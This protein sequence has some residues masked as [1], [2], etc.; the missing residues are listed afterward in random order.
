MTSFPIS[1]L[2]ICLARPVLQGSVLLWGPHSWTRWERGQ[3]GV[4][5][6]GS[7]P[8]TSPQQM[9]LETT[10]FCW[11]G[12]SSGGPPHLVR[13]EG[14][15]GGGDGEVPVVS[16]SLDHTT[17]GKPSIPG[18][19]PCWNLGG[20]RCVFDLPGLGK[21]GGGRAPFYLQCPEPPAHLPLHAPRGRC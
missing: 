21:G 18:L 17:P 1:P 5:G 9:L 6:E 15:V 12:P 11:E 14:V 13:L 19:R 8:A 20:L 3:V 7:T 10:F 2:P 4:Q 16:Q